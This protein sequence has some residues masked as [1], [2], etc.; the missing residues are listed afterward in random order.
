[1]RIVHVIEAT[2]ALAAESGADAL[3]N[4]RVLV[5]ISTC[6]MRHPAVSTRLFDQ[7]AAGRPGNCSVSP[8]IT[9]ESSDGEPD[10]TIGTRFHGDKP[11]PGVAFRTH[12]DVA[13]TFSTVM[14]HE[15]APRARSTRISL[16]M[17]AMRP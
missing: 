11:H 4:G 8:T 13:D 9:L 15:D 2:L 7:P 14:Q 12:R 5:D 17:E 6:R 16:P 1:M 10:L 3:K